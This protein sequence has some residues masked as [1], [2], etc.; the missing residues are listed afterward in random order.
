MIL[1][2]R[3]KWVNN[4]FPCN[5]F[6]GRHINTPYF[7]VHL[8]SILYGWSD[9][10]FLFF[11][12]Q[13]H[14]VYAVNPI[15]IF[16]YHTFIEV[17]VYRQKNNGIK[18]KVRKTIYIST[19]WRKKIFMVQ[20]IYVCNQC[21]KTP[22][23]SPKISLF[24]PIR[25]FSPKE[26]VQQNMFVE[27]ELFF[28]NIFEGKSTAPFLEWSCSPLGIFRLKMGRV[29]SKRGAGTRFPGR[30]AFFLFEFCQEFFW[31]FFIKTFQIV[32]WYF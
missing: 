28:L 8:W 16:K 17:F 25:F 12:Y 26:I 3:G 30:P 32:E 13:I 23:F 7:L 9:Y 11:K 22:F 2:S 19:I 1:C 21:H 31:Y 15:I 4:R 27:K 18:K 20:K 29:T 24:R 10:Y 14:K 6:F 5:F